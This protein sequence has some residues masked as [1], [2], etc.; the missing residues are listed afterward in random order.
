LG[1][2]KRGFFERRGRKG[3][4]KCAEEDREK[5]DKKKN[6]ETDKKSKATMKV[7]S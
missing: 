6:E 4:A 7:E 2:L 5:E 3:F 1:G